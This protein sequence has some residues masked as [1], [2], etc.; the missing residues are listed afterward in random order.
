L[1]ASR[2]CSASPSSGSMPTPSSKK[3]WSTRPS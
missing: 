3:P 1:P 2:A